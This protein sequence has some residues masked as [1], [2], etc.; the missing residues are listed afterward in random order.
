LD[1]QR[2]LWKND[3]DA[4]LV[5]EF[6]AEQITKESIIEKT[7]RSENLPPP[8]FAKEGKPSLL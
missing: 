3:N 2:F 5:R 4:N 7:Y 6:N 8:L 1:F